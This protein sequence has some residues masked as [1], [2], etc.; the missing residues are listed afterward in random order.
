ML[1]G[2]MPEPAAD[3]CENVAR[4]VLAAIAKAQATMVKGATDASLGTASI[5]AGLHTGRTIATVL[6]GRMSPRLAIFGDCVG[7]A[8][9]LES[10]GA[11][12]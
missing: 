12:F 6:G 10:H 11:R 1:I 3:H 8:T 2:G 9:R 7:T 5:R 4:F